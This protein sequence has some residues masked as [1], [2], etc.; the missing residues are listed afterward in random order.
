MFKP[1]YS[2]LLLAKEEVKLFNFQGSA[3]SKRKETSKIF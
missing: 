3:D 2:T 1:L